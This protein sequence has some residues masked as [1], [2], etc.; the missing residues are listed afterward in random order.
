M[1]L[2]LSGDYLKNSDQPPHQMWYPFV[3]LC[4]G[5]TL[6]ATFQ[7][8]G[9]TNMAKIE[10]IKEAEDDSPPSVECLEVLVWGSG[11]K[12]GQEF[13]IGSGANFV[14]G[15]NFWI[16]I[17]YALQDIPVFYTRNILSY[18]GP[19]DLDG[20]NAEL[21]KFINDE[22]PGFGFGDMLPETCILLKRNKSSYTSPTGETQ[23]FVHYSLKVSADMGAVFGHSAP[24]ERM[25]DFCLED[26]DLETGL[27][28]MRELVHEVSEVSQGR[29]PDPASLRPGHSDWPFARQ[30]NHQAYNQI[31]TDYQEDYFSNPLLTEAFDG[32]LAEMPQ[33][34]HIL[35]AGC[36]HGDPVITRILAKGFQVT[37]SDF[38]PAMLAR[39][40]QQF[41]GVQFIQSAINGI[42]LEALFDGA[43]SFQSLLYLD[44][45][46]LL[47]GIF[48]LY[49]AIKPGGWLFLY[50]YD[51]HPGWRGQPYHVDLDHWMWGETYAMDDVAQ[52]LEEHGYFKVLK[53]LDVTTEAER[54][55]RIERWRI[56]TQKDHEELV[57]KLPAESHIP[58]PDLSKPPDRL[59]YPYLVI[60]QKQTM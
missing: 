23:S 57:K 28:F 26:I 7:R 17:R 32:W 33:A 47:H 37:G 41:P 8:T 15:G 29:H 16:E 6:A 36:G 59:A 24:G 27:R 58:A 48:R 54:Q 10:I 60:A 22:H 30:L 53:T 11:G 55:K 13:C 20:L 14:A 2:F 38:S 42:E 50:A 31:S 46:D 9:Q 39:A 35:D 45:I 44:P 21:E 3:S 56:Q 25:L 34:G 4:V 12:R 52:L 19:H 51:L 49:Q 18:L 43:C 1:P 40:R 5:N